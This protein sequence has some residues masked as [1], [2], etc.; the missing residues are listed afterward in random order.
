MAVRPF[1]ATSLRA[2][3]SDRRVLLA[4][5]GGLHL[6]S[7]GVLWGLGLRFYDRELDAYMPF[8]DPALLRSELWTSL[9][10]LHLKP[11]IM[12]LGAG[13]VLQGA[14]DHA[15]LVFTAVYAALGLGL[16]LSLTYLL[17]EIGFGPLGVVGLSLA[18]SLAP[19]T[20]YFE[21]FLYHTYPAAALLMG[22]AVAL[23]RALRTG[24]RRWWV[25]FFGLGALL[26]WTR[27][28]FHLV[29]LV[30]ALAGA[31]VLRW[32]ERRRIL[33][34]V[35]VPGTATLALYAKNLLVFGF[36]GASSWLGI[37]LAKTTVYRLPDTTRTAWVQDGTLGPTAQVDP[38]AGPR[39]YRPFVDE[40]PPTGVAALDRYRKASGAPNYNHRLF[41][42][43]TPRQRQNALTVLQRRPGFYLGV[44][45][46]DFL[47]FLSPI[48]RWHPQD[49]TASPFIPNRALLGGYERLFNTLLH[50]PVGGRPVGV[51]LLAPLFVLGM[52][53]WAAR[54]VWQAR[55]APPRAP[56]ATDGVLLFLAL[57][58][59]YVAAVSCLAE[60][61]PELARFRFL[62]AAPLLVL[63]AAG[64]R[65]LWAWLR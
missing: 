18:F 40:P 38:F 50:A 57:T 48:T 29:W 60:T 15:T 59:I 44:A 28:L 55:I 24:R 11:P 7:R 35:A 45:A 4:V 61:G 22:S 17:G 27:S 52:G 41:L 49:K 5:V 14:G 46:S 65:R 20:L 21:H 33:G 34:A 26:T 3:L 39:A 9:W 56:S 2:A 42:R 37:S 10:Y 53:V 16:V 31:L 47:T 6:L 64:L 54:R 43:V 58:W 63:I 23:H 8:L 51:L 36:F 32:P 30:G 1:A 19:P 13:L 62:V 25:L 12:N